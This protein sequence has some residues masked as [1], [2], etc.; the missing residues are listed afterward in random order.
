MAWIPMAAYGGYEGY[1]AIKAYTD[2]DPAAGKGGNGLAAPIV[3]ASN[4][5]GGLMGQSDSDSALGMSQMNAQTQAYNN[6]LDPEDRGLQQQ[7]ADTYRAVMAGLPTP[8]SGLYQKSVQDAGAAGLSAAAAVHG[9]GYGRASAMRQGYAAQS[10]GRQNSAAGMATMRAQDQQQALQGLTGVANQMHSADLS[11]ARAAG[12]YA[13]SQRQQNYQQGQ[14][15]LGQ[16]N[17]NYANAQ[18]MIVNTAQNNATRFANTVT[19]NGNN[20]LA[21]QRQ[22]NAESANNDAMIAGGANGA[23][24]VIGAIQDS[25]ADPWQSQ[26]VPSGGGS[27]GDVAG[28]G[29]AGAG[30]G[31]ADATQSYSPTFKTNVTTQGPGMAPA[32]GGITADDYRKYRLYGG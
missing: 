32:P 15:Y 20:S 19:G 30:G 12:D 25:G 16:A 17:T 29:G 23:G 21:Q 26:Q 2:K 11:N 27:A 8:Q 7:S 10:S 1:K 18:N 9:G 24:Q 4:A 5:A 22:D 6:V 13:N 28:A 14:F 31:G 3:D